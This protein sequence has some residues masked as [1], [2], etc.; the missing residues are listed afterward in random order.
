MI[1]LLSDDPAWNQPLCDCLKAEGVS[2]TV[3]SHPSEVPPVG[4]LFNRISARY[5][6]LDLARARQIEEFLAAQE[7]VGR[8]VINGSDCFQLGFDKLAQQR[9]FEECEVMTPKTLPVTAG[10][11]ALPELPVLLKPRCSS[12]G[13]G[14]ERLA[15]G[16]QIP[17]S[18]AE[19]AAE[20]IEQEVID[21]HDQAVH[22]VEVIG[23]RILYDAATSLTQD[24][25]NYCLANN[26]QD[27][28][29]SATVNPEIAQQVARVASRSG[30]H[31]GSLEYLIA[32][33]GAA[34]FIDINPVSSYHPGANKVTGRDPN[35]LLAEWFIERL[36]D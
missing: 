30:L 36:D 5:A 7:A 13:A 29:L 12:Y 19:Q 8:Q 2:A 1:V 10:R 6:G 34:Y 23:R 17:L 26:H 35:Q 18:I 31:V 16:V 33:S 3:V 14:I 9:L 20:Y 22:R 21:P 28:Q 32:P 25:F 15:A 24:S 4:L 27:S 11:R